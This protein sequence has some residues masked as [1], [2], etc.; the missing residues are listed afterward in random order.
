MI[1]HA[2]RGRAIL[3]R[4]AWLVPVTSDQGECLSIAR[5]LWNDRP[6]AALA[7]Y[8]E[9]SGARHARYGEFS[10]WSG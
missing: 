9:M 6:S 8:G 4:L 1:G 5:S 7:S 3:V 10:A 2:P